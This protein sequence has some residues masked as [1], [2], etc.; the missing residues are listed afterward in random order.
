MQA[1]HSFFCDLPLLLLLTA[2]CH[3]EQTNVLLLHTASCDS[4]AAQVLGQKAMIYSRLI[5]LFRDC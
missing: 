3:K 2:A 4:A 5:F 1:E